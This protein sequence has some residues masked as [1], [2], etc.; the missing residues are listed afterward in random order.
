LLRE[1]GPFAK[2]GGGEQVNRRARA[3][4][5]I[6]SVRMMHRPKPE[7]RL[8]R[9]GDL[10]RPCVCSWCVTAAGAAQQVL[11]GVCILFSR[12]IPLE[13]PP[14]THP[15]WCLAESFG[16]SCTAQMQE[17]ITHVVT[18]TNGT[19]KARG[20]PTHSGMFSEAPAALKGLEGTGRVQAPLL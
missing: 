4:W 16:A 14:E 17:S 20:S 8:A 1:A 13:Q 15:L 3:T 18:N 9:L 12:V 2:K 11:E 7:G 6:L 10:A 5:C 19:E